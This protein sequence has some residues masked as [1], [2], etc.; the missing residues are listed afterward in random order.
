MI[1]PWGVINL[2][3]MSNQQI[4][5]LCNKCCMMLSSGVTC[6]GIRGRVGFSTFQDSFTQIPYLPQGY[7]SSVH[8]TLQQA[9]SAMVLECPMVPPLIREG[10]QFLMDVATTSSKFD[11]KQLASLN[12][13]RL[14]LQVMTVVDITDVMGTKILLAYMTKHPPERP[15]LTSCLRYQWKRPIQMITSPHR[16]LRVALRHWKVGPAQQR[17]EWKAYFSL[18]RN[19]VYVNVNSNHVTF[20][21]T[22]SES[23]QRKRNT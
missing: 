19:E 22:D 9:N 18:E 5:I 4:K 10:N 6:L 21:Q 16:R 1:A 23:Y 12:R 11:D 8:D 2:N 14:F 13:T 20:K 15:K 3:L 7:F 17:H